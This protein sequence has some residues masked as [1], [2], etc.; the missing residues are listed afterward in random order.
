MTERDPLQPTS[1]SQRET[2]ELAVAGYQD[3]LL[4]AAGYLAG[5]GL[6][7]ETARTFRLGVVD[8]PFPGHERFRG[9][10]AIPY[11]H[12]TGYPKAVRFRCMQDHEH[13]YHGKYNSIAGEPVRIFNPR[14][15][16]EAQHEIHITEGEFDAV[17]LN[18]IGL[19][20]VAIPGAHTWSWHHAITM[21]G[22]S[23]VWVWADP[24][25]AGSEFV[26]KV[27]NSLRSA[28]AVNLKPFGG[29]VSDIYLKH[30]ADALLDL[31][32]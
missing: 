14:A 22:F 12:Y 1:D 11:L 28:R 20:A 23:R 6:T 25:E 30:G 4:K 27:T 5:R 17:I 26:N 8:E 9:M 19:H 10:L 29:D 21:Y 13:Q 32:N 18:Q 31:I 24:D 7:E 15:V 16:I 2:N 3:S